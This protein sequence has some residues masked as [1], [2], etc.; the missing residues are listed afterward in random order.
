MSRFNDATP[1]LPNSKIITNPTQEYPILIR[2]TD[3]N[4]D[5][6]KKIKISTVVKPNELGRFWTRYSNV[7]KSGVSGLKKKDKKKKKKSAK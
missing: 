7:V 5:K 2:I 6:T 1:N 4:S 3:G